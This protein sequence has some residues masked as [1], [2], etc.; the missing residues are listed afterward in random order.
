MI[1]ALPQPIQ[2]EMFE[3]FVARLGRRISAKGRIRNKDLSS[4]KSFAGRVCPERLVASLVNPDW[5]NVAG[6]LEEQT[7]LPIFRPF[8][9]VK[10]HEIFARQLAQGRRMPRIMQALAVTRRFCPICRNTEFIQLGEAG[11]HL[12][13]QLRWMWR[14]QTHRCAL[15]ELNTRFDGPADAWAIDTGCQARADLEVLKAIERDTK[16]LLGARVPPLGTMH[17]RTFHR[18]AL[19]ERFGIQPPYFRAELFKLAHQIGPRARQWLGLS[20]ISYMDHWLVTVVHTPRG[21]TA[22]LLHLATL[23]LCGRK[24]SDAVAWVSP[25][26]S[27]WSVNP[28]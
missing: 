4:G 21:T 17:W 26:A 20:M 23:R 22:P 25:Q 8:L 12:L 16:W 15:W 5:L 14:C 13:H 10:A 27:C 3:S 19:T 7:A 2:G 28:P 18:A 24:I 1:G 11:W 9:D 6:I